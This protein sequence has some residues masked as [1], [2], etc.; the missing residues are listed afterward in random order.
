MS[1]IVL[2]DSY[3]GKSTDNFSVFLLSETIQQNHLSSFCPN[4]V[5]IAKKGNVCEKP[6]Q[7]SN[8]M[9]KSRTRLGESGLSLGLLTSTL[10]AY[11]AHMHP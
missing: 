10:T 6:S 3:K 2:Y 8:K 9:K 11:L 5:E 1:C 4:P 7:N